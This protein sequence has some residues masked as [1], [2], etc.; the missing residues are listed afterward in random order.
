MPSKNASRDDIE[1]I[2]PD[3]ESPPRAAD[4]VKP[5]KKPKQAFQE[6]SDNM[7]GNRVGFVKDYVVEKKPGSVPG[8][9]APPRGGPAAHSGMDA[10]TADVLEE[11]RK[12]REEKEREEQDKEKR[13][14]EEMEIKEGDKSV[15]S[16]GLSDA[17]AAYWDA[18]GQ[19]DSMKKSF[20][21][22]ARAMLSTAKFDSVMGIVI[23]F[24]SVTIGLE[25]DMTVKGQDT[26]L[27]GYLEYVFLVLYGG[28]LGL[29]F[30]V[31]GI[32]C[33]TNPWVQFDA[34]LVAASVLEALI[35]PPVV[36]FLGVDTENSPLGML[37]VFKVLRLFRL[38]RTVRLLAAFK[39][40][41][42]LVRGLMGSVN[43]IFF[44][45]VIIFLIIYLFACIALELI[46]KFDSPA[47]D[48]VFDE[49]V[50]LYFKNMLTCMMTLTQ[51]VTLDS[52]G[53]IYSV[54]IPYN[55]GLFSLYFFG[56]ILIVSIALMNLVTAVIVEGS[57]DQASNDK[58]VQKAYQHAELKKLIPKIEQMFIALDEDGSGSLDY[59]ELINAPEDVKME[60]SKCVPSDDLGELFEMID[61]DGGGEIDVGEFIAGLSQIALSNQ[62][63]DE[64]RQKKMIEVMKKE[65]H[66]LVEKH[67]AIEDQLQ[68]YEDQQSRLNKKLDDIL[69]HLSGGG[70]GGGNS[71]RPLSGNTRPLSGRK[72]KPVGVKKKKE[73]D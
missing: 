22:A 32:K 29:R 23:V 34:V 66:G 16:Q 19:E 57:L 5:P 47:R 4:Q 8:A 20:M 42:M 38:A 50:E 41:W 73:E 61:I 25:A 9:V 13:A 36:F 26:T 37:M 65:I 71:T 28:E 49:Y 51:F 30:I 72:K 31:L 40:L 24:N 60:L 3:A 56:F 55:W 44:T 6:P 11:M 46:T 53:S 17:D 33:L 70:G 15:K 48:A 39:V 54:M 18:L 7:N 12:A 64:I 43:T 21:F 14:V 58:E 62:P 67:T 35:L 1:T 59:E 2:D 45:F 69:S 27:F 63:M 10:S 52:V 68:Q